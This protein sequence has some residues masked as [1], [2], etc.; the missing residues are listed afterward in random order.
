M[1]TTLAILAAIFV[2]VYVASSFWT[3]ILWFSQMK[4][5]RILWTRWG[6]MAG[7][8]VL[9]FAIIFAA[10]SAAIQIAYR[11]RSDS[12]RGDEGANLRHYR[13][14]IEPMRKLVFW[15]VPALI[16]LINAGRLSSQWDTFLMFF[17][18]QPFG[19]SEPIFG[20][21][22][23]F[24]VFTLPFFQ[25]IVSFFMSVTIWSLIAA[26]IVHY[27]YGSLAL[28]PRPHATKSARIHL[29]VMAAIISLLF[30][31]NYWL[32]RYGLLTKIGEP[33]DGALYTD[34]NAQLPAQSIL[35]VISVLVAVLFL[36]AAFKGTW[37]LPL[38]GVVVTVVSAL[39]IGMAYPALIQ[40]LYVTPNARN[41]EAPYIQ[42]NIDA[43]LE[44]YGLNDLE[45]QSY[46]A[47][48]T[49]AP[50]QLR[51]DT[52]STSQIRLL[53]PQVITPTVTQLQ[54]SRPYY[55]FGSGMAVDR[56]VVDGERRDTV[57]AMRELNLEGLSSEQ[58]TWVNRH[59]VYTHGFGVVAA[60]GNQ[61]TTDGLPAYWEKSIPSEGEMGDYEPRIYFSPSSPNYS[62]VGAPEGA[63]PQE[64]DYPDDTA[65]SGQVRYTFQGDGGPSV[66][67]LWNKLLYSIKFG[68]Y[69]IFF[70]SQTNS[71]SQILYDRDPLTRVA[72][73]APYLTLEQKP[74]PAVVDMDDDPSTPKRLVWVVDAYTTS[75][76]YPYSAHQQLDQSTVDSLSSDASQF[77]S[78]GNTVNYM[79]N[80]VKAVVDAYDGHVR[81]FQ[82]DNEDPVLKTWMGVYPNTVEPLSEI[83]GDLMAHLRYPE[84]LF[85]V[86]RDLLTSYHVTEA[87]QYYTGGDLWR[88][89]QETSTAALASAQQQG[90]EGIQQPG[91]STP[92]IPQPPYYLTMQMPGQ[93]SAEFS[94]TSV[95]VP[96]GASKREAMAGFL[97]VDSETGNEPG[98]VREG[99]GKLRLI[100]L[101]SDLTVPGPGQV[102]NAYDSNQQ[103]GSQL[104]LLN[105]SDSTVIRGNLLTL[106]VGGGLLYVQPVYVQGKGTASY[107]VL[108]MVLTA[109]GNQVGFAPT[110][111]E[112]LDQTFGGDSAATVADEVGSSGDEG[113]S[114]SPAVQSAQEKLNAALVQ[115]SQAMQ[116]ADAAMKAGDWAAYGTAQ[117]KL[118]T[119]LTNALN[120]QAEMGEDVSGAA[121]PGLGGADGAQSG[122]TNSLTGDSQSDDGGGNG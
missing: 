54:Q 22:N 84:D 79:R 10:I 106:P 116:E 112:S 44:A 30:G 88:L 12:S 53:D 94:L 5:T 115:A 87:A 27:L 4:S 89:A 95:F 120:A 113:D 81:L 76:A 91:Q 24:F 82:W 11:H 35:A 42:H 7:L 102:Q 38:T 114:T 119:A 43:T 107:P 50:G 2:I 18:R 16:A 80:S 17:K 103:I 23:S 68:S 66:G 122:A 75:N 37:R 51:E 28:S 3:E 65:A 90:V 15:G 118:D 117:K 8:F 6:T 33:T 63:E 69:D 39:V 57:I 93:E 46:E 40:R 104:N 62:I 71:Q 100:A 83:S 72:K 21:D 29:G 34:I 67:N 36:V 31:L 86:Q 45:F 74:Y 41:A 108:R 101:P 14:T 110:L 32:G 109:F 49:A 105:Q 48:T 1:A 98:K 61:V 55:D 121:V 99:Y 25:A 26:V 52:E 73:V 47:R 78:A 59:T 92:Q 97:A 13:D 56:Y 70:S 60:Y 96:G 64:L 9:G 111:Q 20:I 19:K 85:K 58:Q 77:V